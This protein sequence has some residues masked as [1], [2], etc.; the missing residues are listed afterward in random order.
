M[1]IQNVLSELIMKQYLPFMLQKLN[2]VL[3]R[4]V[5]MKSKDLSAKSS[6]DIYTLLKGIKKVFYCL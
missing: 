5:T 2:H 6:L 1:L 4:K 3:W